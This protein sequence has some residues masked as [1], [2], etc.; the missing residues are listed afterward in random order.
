MGSWVGLPSRSIW[1]LALAEA[2]AADAGVVHA[3]RAAA[4]GLSGGA[5]PEG[6][7]EDG[8]AE[9]GVEGFLL[10]QCFKND[11][12]EDRSGHGGLSFVCVLRAAGVRIARILCGEIALNRWGGEGEACLAPTVWPDDYW[13]WRSNWMS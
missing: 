6:D 4:A 1:R 13:G 9:E 10:I 7:G 12:A 2:R 8:E 5:R 11:F 3:M